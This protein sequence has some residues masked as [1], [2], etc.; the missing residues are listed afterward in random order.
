MN[1]NFI[2]SI[3]IDWKQMDHDSY[4]H[5]IEALKSMDVLEF[6]KNV[7]FLSVRTGREN[8][9]CLKQSQSLM[10]LIQRAEP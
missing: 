3:C 4:L 5:S 7:T 6:Q 9:L 10:V 8:Q 2:Q 1:Y